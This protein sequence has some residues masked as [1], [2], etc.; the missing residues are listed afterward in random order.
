M[1][2]NR[3]LRESLFG[4]LLLTALALLFWKFRIIDTA[5]SWFSAANLDM[6]I[7]QQPMTM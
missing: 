7:G 5:Y 1:S 2:G 4:G 3:A 6:F